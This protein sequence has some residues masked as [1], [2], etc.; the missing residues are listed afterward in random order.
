ME[1]AICA[2]F[3]HNEERDIETC[4]DSIT[5]Q[6]QGKIFVLINGC[7]DNTFDVV[8]RYSKIHNTVVPIDLKVG[9]KSNAW[10]VFVHEINIEAEHY[11]FV[12]G[13]CTVEDSAFDL[14]LSKFEKL[15]ESKL[16]G[17]ACTPKETT[18][19]RV[20]QTHEMIKEGQL[21][22][23]FY[24]LTNHFIKRVRCHNI[25]LPIGTIGE[26]G[27]VGA[28]A[29]WDL[30]PFSKW[31]LEKVHVA[32]DIKFDYRTLSIFNSHDLKLYYRR[33]I[34]YSERFFQNKIIT[35]CF[36]DK[37]L[38]WL[39]GRISDL[40]EHYEPLLK[41]R[42]RGVNTYFDW[43]ALRALKRQFK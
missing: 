36:R 33:K 28:L 19:N 25:Y 37:G 6:F 10:N 2:V 35:E 18:K 20:K 29:F 7:T 24:A 17:I 8:T 11:F 1:H 21:A 15:R 39:S 14:A 4:L 3:A 13:D 5:R 27:L 41:V 22:G 16:N 26:D 42:F 9:D 43:I 32:K 34:R 38:S 23:N 30:K 12:D 40:Y 31:D